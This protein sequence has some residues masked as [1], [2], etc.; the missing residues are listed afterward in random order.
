MLNKY[1]RGIMGMD[2]ELLEK[3]YGDRN[4]Y[5]KQFRAKT[6]LDATEKFCN[7]YMFIF[8]AICDE[9]EAVEENKDV[10]MENFA[11]EFVSLMADIVKVG[12]K[13][14]KSRDMLETNLYMVMYVFPCVIETGRPDSKELAECII[15]RWNKAFKNT[16]VSLSDYK[17]I[18]SG[19]KRKMCYIT[20]AVC[21]SFD[22]PDD[23]YELTTLRRFRDEYMASSEEGVKLIEEYYEKAPR[24][25]QTI[26]T[27]ADAADVYRMLFDT[28]IN[29]CICMIETGK[30][31][32]CLLHYKKMVEKLSF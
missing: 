11:D 16:N 4:Y 15:A 1:V 26:N 30:M 27:R 28:Y 24:I 31:E 25:V 22:K 7:E 29:P 21:D 12:G 6:Y 5:N 14:P 17:S 2:K 3:M 13:Q 18:D 9:I 8:N 10:I 23:C 19:F 32:E 20:T